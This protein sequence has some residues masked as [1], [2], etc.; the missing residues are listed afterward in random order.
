MSDF[1]HIN[2]NAFNIAVMDALEKTTVVTGWQQLPKDEWMFIKST[3]S[4][5]YAIRDNGDKIIIKP[6]DS[7]IQW[8]DGIPIDAKP[9][10][11]TL[12]SLTYWKTELTDK[13]IIDLMWLNLDDP[14]QRWIYQ[15]FI[16]TTLK[17]L[18]KQLMNRL[19]GHNSNG[20]NKRT[21]IYG[22]WCR[23]HVG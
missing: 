22:N 12:S 2:L 5:T 19:K 13:D 10:D 16:L 9:F 6:D 8:V 15:R 11:G 23:H 7:P 20:N 1:E 14:K 21:S 3:S 4:E 17:R 18:I